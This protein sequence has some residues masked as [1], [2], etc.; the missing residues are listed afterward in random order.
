M[1]YDLADEN[2][3]P[4]DSLGK[5]NMVLSRL[6][7]LTGRIDNNTTQKE[8]D[9]R[10]THALDLINQLNEL[11]IDNN[12]DYTVKV[13]EIFKDAPVLISDKALLMWKT[14][15]ALGDV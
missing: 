5:I 15:G 9:E 2:I 14:L 11:K 3:D 7:N 12:Q 8:L 6:D 1:D 4:K 13:F 10:Y